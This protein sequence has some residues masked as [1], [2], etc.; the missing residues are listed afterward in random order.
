MENNYA[1]RYT[2]DTGHLY[3]TGLRKVDVE[4]DAASFN[5]LQQVLAAM[6]AGHVPAGVVSHRVE[7]DTT[8]L[9]VYTLTTG[10][11]LLR[12]IPCATD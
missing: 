8:S 5:V 6:Q 12:E 2:D 3:I 11:N 4:S 1:L 9:G 10:F 7:G